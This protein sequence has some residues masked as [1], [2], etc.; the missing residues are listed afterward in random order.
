[1]YKMFNNEGV[2]K[3]DSWQRSCLFSFSFWLPAK[4]DSCLSKYFRI[5]ILLH[6]QKK[7]VVY[8]EK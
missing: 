7:F 5:I 1:M 6:K 4:Y 2:S 8:I 3:Q